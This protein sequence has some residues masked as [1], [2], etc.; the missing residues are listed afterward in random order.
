MRFL[1][2]PSNDDNSAPASKCGGRIITNITVPQRNSFD[3][4]APGAWKIP[5]PASPQNLAGI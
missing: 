1:D 2:M 5:T 4:P 3:I